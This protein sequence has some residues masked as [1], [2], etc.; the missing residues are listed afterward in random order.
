MFYLN[1][2]C[3]KII[4]VNIDYRNIF[5]NGKSIIKIYKKN[6]LGGSKMKIKKKV[7]VNFLVNARMEGEQMI[8]ECKI[9]Y[10]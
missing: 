6:K 5:M 9:L 10:L 4:F 1:I 3:I 7:L 2:F 8:D